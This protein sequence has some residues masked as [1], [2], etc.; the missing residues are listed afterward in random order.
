M[1]SRAA[2]NAAVKKTNFVA[3]DVQ[4]LLAQR[5]EICSARDSMANDA[6]FS[7]ASN[8]ALKQAAILKLGQISKKPSKL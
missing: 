3:A 7:S 1:A 8:A 5:F 4:Y 2:A 6:K